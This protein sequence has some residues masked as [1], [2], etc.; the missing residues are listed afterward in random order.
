MNKICGWSTGGLILR[1]KNGSA[2]S[3]TCP[4]TTFPTLSPKMEVLTAKPVP[5]PLCPPWVQKWKCS[6]QNLSQY[7][8][9]HPE[10]KNGS[11][12]SKTCPS[13]TLSTLSPHVLAWD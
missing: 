4:S 9:V 10:S 8:F 7:H 5:V 1:G 12:H 11:A 3:K 13:T 2:H 6:Q